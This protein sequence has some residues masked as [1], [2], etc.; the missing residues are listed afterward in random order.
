MKSECGEHQK[1]LAAYSLGDL[2]KEE[3]PALEAHLSVCS[4]CRSEQERYARTIGQ[5]TSPGEEEI[6]HHFFIYPEMQS[7]SP[8]QTFCRMQRRWQAIFAGV[9]AIILLLGI[10]AVSRL[11]IQSN[12]YEWSINFGRGDVDPTTLK[13]GIVEAAKMKNLESR[14]AWIHELQTEITRLEDSLTQQQ[15][16][17]IATAL[18]RMNS[19][20]TGHIADSEEHVRNET[21]KL[22][23]DTYRIIAQQRARDL[24]IINLRFDSTDANHAIESQ[25]TNEILDTLLQVADIKVQ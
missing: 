6:P 3:K 7:L 2:S 24:E 22:I 4:F 19:R 13:K 21:Q 15:K 17:Q 11:Q 8:W 20:I 14:D 18:A 12:S 10:A 23:S 16:N 1:K 9:A 25:Q 5:L